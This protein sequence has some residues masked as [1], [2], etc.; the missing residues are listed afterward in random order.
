MLLLFVGLML[1]F[2]SLYFDLSSFSLFVITCLYILV[3]CLYIPSFFYFF[4][5]KQKTAYEMRIS[6]WSSDVCSSDLRPEAPLKN[7]GLHL[8]HSTKDRFLEERAP[9]GLPWAPLNPAYA[10]A[11]RGPGILRELG[12]AGGLMGSI[13]YEVT[14]NQLEWGTN[15]VHAAVH[16]LGATIRPRTAEALVFPI[17]GETVIAKSVTIPAREFLGVSADD[18]TEILAIL[19]DFIADATGR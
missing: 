17:G 11:K 4:F 15:K 10:A 3:L 2:L 14:G 6:D 7:I 18:E 13:S 5:F 12:N 8:V 19:E 16:Q 1:C 9:D